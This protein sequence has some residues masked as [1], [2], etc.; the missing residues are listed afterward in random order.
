MTDSI[1][2][3]FDPQK[4]REE[5]ATQKLL[6][7]LYN[8]PQDT[9]LEGTVVAISL[10]NQYI[11]V[12]YKCAFGD[13]YMGNKGIKYKEGDKIQFVYYGDVEVDNIPC[14]ELFELPQK[15]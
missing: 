3:D 15:K 13:I 7:E 2:P 10:N 14:L 11:R 4:Y 1:Q 9:V 5:K 6:K 12:Q 8:I